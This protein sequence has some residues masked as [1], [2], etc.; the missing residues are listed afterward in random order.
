MSHDEPKLVWT[1]QTI[2][3]H[4]QMPALSQ[5]RNQTEGGV[6]EEKLGEEGKKNSLAKEGQLFYKKNS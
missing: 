4:L 2:C 3:K 1:S 6:K 5:G